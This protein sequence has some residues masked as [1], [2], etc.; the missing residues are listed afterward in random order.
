LND[1]AKSEVTSSSLPYLRSRKFFIVFL[2][3]LSAQFIDLTIGTLSDLFVD[4]A[5]SPL[6]IGLFITIAM[7]YGVGQYIVLNTVKA[8]IKQSEAKVW[9]HVNL[10][11]NAVTVTQYVLIAIMASIV[12]QIIIN[13]GYYTSLLAISAMISYGL[14]AILTGLL[15]Y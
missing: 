13:S 7:I 9:T 15:A 10:V 11:R 6:G 8:A 4:F 5:V 12:L 1:K 14:A 2:V 3:I